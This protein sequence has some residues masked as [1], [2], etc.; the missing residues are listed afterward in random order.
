MEVA[1][2]SRVLSASRSLPGYVSLCTEVTA[3]RSGGTTGSG[4]GCGAGGDGAVAWREER[5]MWWE[6]RASVCVCV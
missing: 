1:A 6:E 3:A 2:S 4:D 5:T